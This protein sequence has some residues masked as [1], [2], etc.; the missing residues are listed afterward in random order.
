VISI[1]VSPTETLY[2][3]YTRRTSPVYQH[4]IDMVV[5]LSIS[6]GPSV[7]MNISVRQHRTL[8]HWIFLCGKVYYFNTTII[9]TLM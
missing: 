3:D 9:N 8:D 7:F 4:V 5:S 1:T 2:F 6:R